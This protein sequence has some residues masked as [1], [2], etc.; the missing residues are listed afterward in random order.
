MMLIGEGANKFAEEMGVPK[1]D[2]SEL[3]TPSARKEWEEYDKYKSVISKVFH[4]TQKKTKNEDSDHEHDT[5]GAVAIDL[6][7]NMAAATS[8]GGISLKKVGRVGD[9][10]L[11]GSGAYC[12]NTLGGISCTGHGE[13]IA[14]VV[15]GYRALNQLQ[16]D[17]KTNL[18]KALK[19]SLE[20]MLNR[21][22]GR[23]GMIGISRNGEIAKD[24][25]TPRMSWASV[26]QN[27]VMKSGI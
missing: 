24:F 14:K 2:P 19:N 26:D 12:D 1:V 8:T 22:G 27:G 17:P 23:G 20:F 18:E 13:A 10:P 7:G 16:S 21:V 3:A 6:Q 5:V 9:S 15:L 25:S 4:S 11:V